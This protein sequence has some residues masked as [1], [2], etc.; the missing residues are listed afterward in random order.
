MPDDQSAD[1]Q[2]L[3][4]QADN[5]HNDA[6]ILTPILLMALII[7]CGFMLSGIIAPPQNTA[8]TAA[9]NTTAA[10]QR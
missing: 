6:R 3:Q 8:H 10:V 4:L 2:N 9:A 7:V 5:R 1:L